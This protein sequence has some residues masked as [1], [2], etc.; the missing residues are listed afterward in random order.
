MIITF[1]FD[2]IF[3]YQFPYGCSIFSPRSNIFCSLSSQLTRLFPYRF[4]PHRIGLGQ[5]PLHW[6]ATVIFANDF[7]CLLIVPSTIVFSLGGLVFAIYRNKSINKPQWPRQLEQPPPQVIIHRHT[8]A[9]VNATHIFPS[10][11]SNQGFRLR[12]N[13]AQGQTM[14]IERLYPG[15]VALSVLFSQH[16]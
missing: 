1:F 3:F 5:P 7:D 11:A 16:T 14:F 10:G 2:F 15:R 6:H 9:F 13:A 8:Q 12:N 4:E